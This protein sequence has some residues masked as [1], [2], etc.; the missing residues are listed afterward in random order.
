MA[1]CVTQGEHHDYD[2]RYDDDDSGYV[3]ADEQVQQS[4]MQK[5]L[6][7][8]YQTFYPPR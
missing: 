3:L 1:A 6:I 4:L 8:I 7:I 5:E 2:G